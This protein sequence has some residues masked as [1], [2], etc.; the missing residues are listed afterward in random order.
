[1][2]PP[3]HSDT[4][5]TN[6]PMDTDPEPGDE[7]EDGAGGQTD[8]EDA[9]E[10]N[11]W[12]HPWNWEAIMEEAEGLAYDDLWSDSDA[13]VM[14]VDG[15]QGPAL[16]LHDEAAN[17]P[18]HTPRHAACIC[19]GRQW[20]ICHCWRQQSPAET[21]LRCMSMRRSWTTSEPE[22]HRWASRCCGRYTPEY[23]ARFVHYKVRGSCNCR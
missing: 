15:S 20:T 6:P 14:G 5:S 11:R 8:S 10:E 16:S 22:A 3:H 2:T 18:P 21:P 17:S 19:Q 23:I 7:S 1:M 13:M 4:Q 9:A 12:W